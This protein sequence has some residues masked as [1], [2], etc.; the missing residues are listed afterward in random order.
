MPTR[1]YFCAM[2]REPHGVPP[3]ALI[4]GG[5]LLLTVP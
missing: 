2:S 5:L 1:H 3:V 4:L